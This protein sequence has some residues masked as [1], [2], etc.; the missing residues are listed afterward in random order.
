MFRRLALPFRL[1]GRYY[2][3]R[4]QSWALSVYGY[5]ACAELTSINMTMFG[6]GCSPI[7]VDK[8]KQKLAMSD[9]IIEFKLQHI[10]V[11]VRDVNTEWYGLGLQ[12]G[13]PEHI[14]KP[15]GSHPDVED[16]LRVMLSKWLDYDP[17]ACWNKLANALNTMGKNVI[18]A[19]IRSEY[20]R[21]VATP[22]NNPNPS[23]D[24]KTSMSKLLVQ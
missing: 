5:R 18:A 20:V 21:A 16:R 6:C 22:V 24:D 2:E 17:Q 10:V 11:A 8:Q 1:I 9:N 7:K 14:L 4:L 23:D 13:L 3:P 12:L 15:I 19:N